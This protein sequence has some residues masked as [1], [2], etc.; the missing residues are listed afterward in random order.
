MHP[1]NAIIL[2]AST[3]MAA[4]LLTYL[5][6]IWPGRN[7]HSTRHNLP[8]ILVPKTHQTFDIAATM[9]CAGKIPDVHVCVIA[10]NAEHLRRLARA[11]SIASYGQSQRRV[12]VSVF[13]DSSVV[14]R[15]D[16]ELG[17]GD[18]SFTTRTLPRIRTDNQT[19]VVVLEDHMETSPLHGLW[20][21]TQWCAT[22]VDGTNHTTVIGGGREDEFDTAGLA[23]DPDTWNSFARE[24]NHT[25]SSTVTTQAILNHIALLPNPSIILPAHGNVFVRQQWQNAAYV[26]RNPRLTRTW[27]PVKEPSWGA[28]EIGLA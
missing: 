8:R 21:M 16:A 19:L 7:P 14:Q 27:D 26:E 15:L 12:T 11:L 1:R 25:T 3:A 6:L 9:G 20:F 24:I 13:G 23:M 22:H 10:R 4:I 18:Y 17:Q 28:V 5:T 2:Q